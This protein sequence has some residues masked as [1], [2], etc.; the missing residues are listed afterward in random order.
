MGI[1]GLGLVGTGNGVRS[2]FWDRRVAEFPNISRSSRMD[3]RGDGPSSR[4]DLQPLPIST[5]LPIL[6]Y[7]FSQITEFVVKSS[8]RLLGTHSGGKLFS[9]L[10]SSHH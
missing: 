7:M 8:K 10:I 2:A 3:S 6:N 9:I 5:D 1:L 4:S